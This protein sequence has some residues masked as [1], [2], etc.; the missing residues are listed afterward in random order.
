MQKETILRRSLL[1]VLLCLL[2]VSA[3]FAQDMEVVVRRSFSE[4]NFDRTGIGLRFGPLWSDSWGNWHAKLVPELEASHFSY[5]GKRHGNSSLNQFGGIAMF[6]LHYGS[7]KIRPYVDAGLGAS[8]FNHTRFG[9]KVISTRFQ[10]S[11]H[12]GLGV[13]IDRFTIGWQYSHYSNAGIKK[14]NDGLD[15]HQIIFGVNF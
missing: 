6:R 11:E 10:F 4:N 1:T 2:P 5:D 9:S 15:M 14:P 13:Q 3:S 12:L 8:Y 7:G